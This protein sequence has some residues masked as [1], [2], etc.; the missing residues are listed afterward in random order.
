M[1]P[2]CNLGHWT[3]WYQCPKLQ[4]DEI[5][6]PVKMIMSR[7]VQWRQQCRPAV[8]WDTGLI[9]ISV[10]SYSRMKLLPPLYTSG[11]DCLD[12]ERGN[13]LMHTHWNTVWS[14]GNHWALSLFS[15]TAPFPIIFFQIDN[16]GKPSWQAQIRGTK[17]WT[18]E[19]PRECEFE[20]SRLEVTV[21]PNDISGC[22]FG[23]FFCFEFCIFFRFPIFKIYPILIF[24]VVLD[25]DTWYHGTTII[26]DE[27][28]ITIG[29]EYDWSVD[30]GPLCHKFQIVPSLEK[31]THFVFALHV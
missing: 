26:G 17:H 5:A 10:P 18:L 19:P 27:I 28:S 8:T 6:F 30:V 9:K 3:D 29:S 13:C 4:P 14:N 31:C 21:Y 25:T 11:H 20:C 23:K 12:A 24:V 7:G 22:L 15:F 1:S 16:V 2:G